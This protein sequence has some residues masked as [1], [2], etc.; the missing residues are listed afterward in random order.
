M[1]GT[2]PPV[3]AWKP[4]PGVR[5]AGETFTLEIAR[6]RSFQNLVLTVPDL[7]DPAYLPER[8]LE[9][10]S[11]WW[12]WSVSGRTADPFRFTIAE[13]SVVLEV[14]SAEALLKA[15]SAG[16]P[17]LFLR[18]DDIDDFRSGTSGGD[19]TLF[20]S[21][22]ELLAQDHEIAEPEFLPDRSVDY[23]AFW[24]IWFPTMWGSR[25]FVKGAETLALAWLATGRREYA[26]AAC[27][28]MASISQWDPHGSSHIDHNDEAHM[29]VIWNGSIACDYVW[30]EFTDAERRSVISQFRRRGEITFEHMHD[31]GMYGI[32]RFDS[33]AGRE[34]VFLA[35]LAIVFHDEIPEARRWLD[36][37]RPVLCGIWPVWAGD[38]GGWAEGVSYSL[39]YVTIMT[40]FA[41][42]L[43][44]GTGIDLYRRPFW[45]NHAHWRRLVH[46]PYAEWIGFG[47]HTERWGEGWRRAADLV[48]LISLET[49]AE[50][51]AYYVA[52][53]RVAAEDL[54]TP[55][56]RRMPGVFTQLLV[57]SRLAGGTRRATGGGA[58]AGAADAGTNGP[59]LSVFPAVGWATIRTNPTDASSDI[60]FIFRSSPFGSISHSHANNNDFILHVAGRVLLMPSGYYAG[61]GSDHHAHWVWHTKS[62]NCIT[63]SDAPQR[64]RSPESVGSVDNA[65]EDEAIVYCRGTA[66]ASYAGRADRLRRHVVYV[67]EGRYLLLIDEFVATAGVFSSLQWNVHSWAQFEVDDAARTFTVRR[68][69]RSVTGHIMHNRTGFFSVTDGWDPPPSSLKSNDQWLPQHNLRFTPSDL[70]GRRRVLGVVLCPEYEGHSGPTV[71]TELV[72][73][74]RPAERAMIGGD[75]VVLN[76]S[77]SPQPGEVDART[78]PAA[79]AGLVIA[80]LTVAGTQYRITDAGMAR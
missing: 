54:P 78:T 68:D 7:Q 69:G 39:P 20:D 35:L 47:D 74:E 51:L 70:V 16:H 5:E 33:H 53:M 43:K 76:V 15:F 60:A 36:W 26:R 18:A 4:A 66:D 9:A 3:F 56:E 40:M 50:E 8:A 79:D 30:D 52:S 21:A 42:A 44:R 29:S 23:Q 32:D 27:T 34:I 11:Y 28:R 49:G 75:S 22:D 80:E 61:Y 41:S 57:T 65:F 64:L 62:H 1:P 6:D 13:E 12:R 67:K 2:N 25:R 58:P 24:K 38:D 63:L 46:P 77:R 10:G 37:L 19:Q 72:A 73:G 14:P 48:E 31:H 45:R 55:P 17:R 71:R 59:A